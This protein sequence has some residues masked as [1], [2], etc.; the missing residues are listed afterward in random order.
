MKQDKFILS[1][2]EVKHVAALAHLGLTKKEI[3]KFQKQLSQIV[4][5]VNQLSEV[6]TNNVVPTSQVTGLENVFREDVVT[7]SLSREKVLANAPDKYKEF[8]K[9]RPVLEK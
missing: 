3:A 6:D 9:V 7:P 4:S 1:T 5:F 2:D 8:F